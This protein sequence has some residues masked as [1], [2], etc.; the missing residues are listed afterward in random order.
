MQVIIRIFLIIL[1]SCSSGR[2]STQIPQR[3]SR[4]YLLEDISGAYRVEAQYAV[5]DNN[6]IFKK[7]LFDHENDIVEK[8]FIINKF[9]K[10]KGVFFP[11]VSQATTWLDKKKHFSEIKANLKSKKYEINAS[12]EGKQKSRNFVNTRFVCP[13]SMIHICTEKFLNLN[14]LLSRKKSRLK[15]WLYWDQYPYNKIIYTDLFGSLLDRASLVYNR[16]DRMNHFFDLEFSGQVASLVFSKSLKFEK[17]Y[18]VAQGLSLT[19]R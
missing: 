12:P 10:A 3:E 9:N 1:F 17:F 16:S 4:E 14:S 11:K 5:K 15:V 2:L 19:V 6:L 13:F 7:T 18:W 8:I